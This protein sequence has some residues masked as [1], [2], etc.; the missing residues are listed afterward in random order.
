MSGIQGP[1]PISQPQ[2]KR[3]KKRVVTRDVTKVLRAL[4]HI[5]TQLQESTY[6]FRFSYKWLIRSLPFRRSAVTITSHDTN[7]WNVFRIRTLF[8]ADV[9]TFLPNNKP[10]QSRTSIRPLYHSA[11][12]PVQ[13][14][15][16]GRVCTVQ[17]SENALVVGRA[18]KTPLPWLLVVWCLFFRHAGGL[19]HGPDSKLTCTLVLRLSA[20]LVF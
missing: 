3:K 6:T 19:F 8:L 1:F 14:R 18:S 5:C 11:R 13:K 2:K 20:S 10:H 17:A 15:P 4:A 9:A 16:H 12:S 7:K